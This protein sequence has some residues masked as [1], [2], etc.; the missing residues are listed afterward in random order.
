MDKQRKILRIARRESLKRKSLRRESFQ[1]GDILTDKD[2]GDIV[3]LRQDYGNGLLSVEFLDGSIQVVSMDQYVNQ[4]GIGEGAPRES[5]I[6]NGRQRVPRGRELYEGRELHERKEL[7][8]RDIKR[9]GVTRKSK[10]KQSE[11]K[12]G[13]VDL[14]SD[15][16][17]CVHKVLLPEGI[18]CEYGFEAIQDHIDRGFC[19]TFEVQER[20]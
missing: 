12:F 8:E 14:P 17:D 16:L 4:R 15:C 13:D 2:T 9:Q 19:E 6:N 18:T 10:T 3:F 20:L 11:I 5:N 7:H 1:I